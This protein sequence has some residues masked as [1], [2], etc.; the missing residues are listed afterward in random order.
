MGAR[1]AGLLVLL[2]GCISFSSVQRAD[3]LGPGR[4]QASVEPGLWG[5]ATTKGAVAVP[6]VDAM[7]RVGVTERLDLGLRAGSSLLQLQ[8]KVLLTEPGDP[9]LAVSLVPALGGSLLDSAGQTGTGLG[10]GPAGALSLDLP[11]LIG[12]KVL[13]DS[14][15]VL[16]PRALTL[17]LFPDG[18]VQ[19]ALALGGSLGFSWQIT[20]GFA[21]MPEVSVVTP[22]TGRAAAGRIFQG[23]DASGVFAS[24]KLGVTFGPA[25]ESPRR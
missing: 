15:V 4:V 2:S 3:T 8:A 7:V 23:L 5:A 1:A 13:E 14:E 18:P 22:V 6:H 10:A 9:W 17:V 24:L 19:A 16:G 11:V 21:L 12:F 25:R 20:S